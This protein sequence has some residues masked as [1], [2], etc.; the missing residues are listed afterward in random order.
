MFG[1]RPTSS[2]SAAPAMMTPGLL[3]TPPSQ[4]A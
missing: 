4:Q 2:V 3:T 1:S